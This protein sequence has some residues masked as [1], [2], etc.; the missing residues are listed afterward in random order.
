MEFLSIKELQK[1]SGKLA[2]CA[3]KNE[4][5]LITKRSVPLGVVIPFDGDMLLHE[6]KVDIVLRA[7]KEG[8]LS[9]G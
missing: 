4:F 5:A 2:K 3:K 7:Y 8:C 1:S 6:L 9:L